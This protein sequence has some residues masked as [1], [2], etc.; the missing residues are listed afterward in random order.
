MG[1]ERLSMRSIR[2]VLRQKWVL[3]KS[4]RE[5]A[6]SIGVSAGVGGLM[7]RVTELG[8]DWNAI[9]GLTDGALEQRLYGP[10]LAS[11]AQ[12]PLPDPVYIHNERKKAGV[13]LELLHLE[14]LEQHPDGY[15]Y[16][17]SFWVRGDPESRRRFRRQVRAALLWIQSLQ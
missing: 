11:G 5:V 4:H 2:E 17:Q 12:R 9:Q 13:T 16:P 15:R 1:T 6:R 14:Y 8:R 10:K 7:V 3:K